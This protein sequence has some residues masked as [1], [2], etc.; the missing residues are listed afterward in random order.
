MSRGLLSPFEGWVLAWPQPVK[1]VLMLVQSAFHVE[2]SED[3]LPAHPLPTAVRVCGKLALLDSIL[4]KLL[5]AGHKVY[6][7]SFLPSRTSVRCLMQCLDHAKA[8][9]VGHRVLTV[10]PVCV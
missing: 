10:F 5:A 2:G 8:S 7:A 1:H 3:L 4:T 9:L 6:L